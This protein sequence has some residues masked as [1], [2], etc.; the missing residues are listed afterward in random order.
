MNHKE[1]EQALAYEYEYA[2]KEVLRYSARMAAVERERPILEALLAIPG[3]EDVEHIGL[4]TVWDTGQPRI[5]LNLKPSTRDSTFVREVVK[6][7][8]ITFKKE[9]SG[10]GLACVADILGVQVSINNYLPYNCRIEYVEEMV[11]SH[12][13]RRAKVVC[14]Q[15]GGNGV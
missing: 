6:A 15:E 3:H 5:D 13:E 8:H 12:I 9:R 4:R 1:V 2:A 7:L 10:D 11:P 14:N